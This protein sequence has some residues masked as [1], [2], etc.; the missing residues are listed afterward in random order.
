ML[1][2]KLTMNLKKV[3]KWLQ[4]SKLSLNTQKTKLMIFHRIQNH[5]KELNIVIHGT[6]IDQVESLNFLGL[7]ID[8]TLSWAQHVEIV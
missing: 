8:E 6:K 3:A 5:M 1:A 2:M 4:M 7:S